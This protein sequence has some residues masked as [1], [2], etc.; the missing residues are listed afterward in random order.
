MK[1]GGDGFDYDAN[2]AMRFTRREDAE[3]AIGHLIKDGTADGCKATEHIWAA[4]SSPSPAD[5][6][7]T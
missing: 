2:K 5:K 7:E 6:K 4:L 1:N 3:G